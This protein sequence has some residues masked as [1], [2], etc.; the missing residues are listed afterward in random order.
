MDGIF[1]STF[2]LG[3]PYYS[4]ALVGISDL[5]YKIRSSLICNLAY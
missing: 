2:L 1:V 4:D 3:Q 5:L